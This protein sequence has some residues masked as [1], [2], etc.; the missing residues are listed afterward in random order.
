MS[1]KIEVRSIEFQKK[2]SMGWPEHDRAVV[3][4]QIFDGGKAQPADLWF[5]VMPFKDLN[6]IGDSV[7]RQLQVF[8]DEIKAAAATVLAPE[9]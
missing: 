6:E 1:V 2:A 9:D 7:R 5:E 4:L 3:K 8:A